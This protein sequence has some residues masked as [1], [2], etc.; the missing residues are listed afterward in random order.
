MQEAGRNAALF[1]RPATWELT[2]S[3]YTRSQV[4]HALVAL[5]Y[6]P[7]TVGL[8]I[9]YE[10][11]EAP[12]VGTGQTR[13]YSVAEVVAI[14]TMIAL[15]DLGLRKGV[16]PPAVESRKFASL[17]NVDVRAIEAALRN[18]PLVRRGPRHRAA[19]ISTGTAPPPGH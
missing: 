12:L 18:A 5:G 10:S 13:Q 17:I 3:T 11:A 8:W 1:F 16:I 2:L 4:Q 19:P 14:A 7:V 9:Q 15:H 6:D